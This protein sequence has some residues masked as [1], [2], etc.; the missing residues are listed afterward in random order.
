[1]GLDLASQG[2]ENKDKP[3]Q[4]RSSTMGLSLGAPMGRGGLWLCAYGPQG[5]AT[6]HLLLSCMLLGKAFEL[7]QE[8]GAARPPCGGHGGQ[9]ASQHS[10]WH[11]GN[12]DKYKPP[13]LAFISS[14]PFVLMFTSSILLRVLFTCLTRL[15]GP[16]LRAPT[17]AGPLLVTRRPSCH[18]DWGNGS[19]H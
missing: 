6:A 16:P 19:G 15:C 7:L 10:L 1:M 18:P 4:L 3:T 14:Q 5:E 11:T 9:H 8:Q 2:S 12:V 13:F 17:Q